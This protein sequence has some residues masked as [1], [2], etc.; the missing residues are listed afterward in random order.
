[1]SSCAMAGSGR[2]GENLQNKQYSP[3]FPGTEYQVLPVRHA[4]K[5][6]SVTQESEN[7]A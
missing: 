3:V 6:L 2:N 5:V 1:M 4:R 7:Y